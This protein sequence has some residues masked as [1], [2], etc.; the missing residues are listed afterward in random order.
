MS[1]ISSGG[2]MRRWVFATLCAA[3]LMVVIAAG[4]PCAAAVRYVRPGG[5]DTASGDSPDRAWQSIPHALANLS[6]GDVLVVGEGV[7]F[8]DD[9]VGYTFEGLDRC[10]IVGNPR[11]S[12]RVVCLGGCANGIGLVGACR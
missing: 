12:R 9:T 1:C 10:W 3:L 8:L 2:P 11:Q 4:L 7:Y 6:G 5:D